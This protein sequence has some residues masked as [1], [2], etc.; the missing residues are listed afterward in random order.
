MFNMAVMCGRSEL[1]ATF[2][3]AKK[4]ALE[5]FGDCSALLWYVAIHDEWSI[6]THTAN[7]ISSQRATHRGCGLF[8]F[9][10]LLF[11]YRWSLLNPV[12]P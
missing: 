1:N 5:K 9:F 2:I 12:S 7:P 10:F 3:L 8:F 11:C 4:Q 6:S